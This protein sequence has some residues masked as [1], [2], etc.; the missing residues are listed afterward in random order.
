MAHAGRLDDRANGLGKRTS[1][2]GQ[3]EADWARG[4]TGARRMIVRLGHCDAY[5]DQRTLGIAP[6]TGVLVEP[7]VDEVDTDG[8]IRQRNKRG[9]AT[10]D[11]RAP[12]MASH[13]IPRLPG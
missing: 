6:N 4:V 7:G 12:S 3:E 9:M 2:V 10:D 11:T 8:E 13:P 1:K 5:P